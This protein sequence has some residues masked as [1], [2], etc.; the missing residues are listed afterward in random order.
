MGKYDEDL[1]RFIKDLNR[2]INPTDYFLCKIANEL[3]EKNRLTRQRLT[4]G[5]DEVIDISEA[6]D[7]A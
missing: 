4:M 1:G 5:L 2:E 6:V 7:K 3:A